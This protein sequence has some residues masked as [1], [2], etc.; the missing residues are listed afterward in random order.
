HGN[1]AKVYG[2]PDIWI[3]AVVGITFIAAAIYLRRRNGEI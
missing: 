3:G 1:P 2:N